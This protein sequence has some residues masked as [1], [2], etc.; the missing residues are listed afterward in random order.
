MSVD[1]ISAPVCVWPKVEPIPKQALCNHRKEQSEGH[2]VM[3]M[4]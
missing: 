1:I 4:V 2:D 3:M